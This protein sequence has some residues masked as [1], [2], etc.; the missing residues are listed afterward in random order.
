MQSFRII[1]FNEKK[2]L[3]ELVSW[4]TQMRNEGRYAAP[5]LDK[6]S[7]TVWTEGIVTITNAKMD[8]GRALKDRGYSVRH[9]IWT[10]IK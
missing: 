6:I 4:L 2:K 3:N 1:L 7:F 8:L 10:E 5:D 9:Q